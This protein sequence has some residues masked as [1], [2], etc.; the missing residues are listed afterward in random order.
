MTSTKMNENTRA[1]GPEEKVAPVHNMIERDFASELIEAPEN[2]VIKESY[3]VPRMGESYTSYTDSFMNLELLKRGEREVFK[4]QQSINGHLTEETYDLIRTD[5]LTPETLASTNPKWTKITAEPRYLFLKRRYYRDNNGLIHDHLR[6]D[7]I[8]CEPVYVFD[9]IMG[10]HLMNNHGFVKKIHHSLS[11]FY[12]NITR[13]LC[14]KALKFCS[15]CNPEQKIGKLEKFKHRNIYNELMPLERVHIEIFEPF[16]NEKIEKKYSHI[17]YCRDYHSRYIWMLPLKN[18]KFK[19]LVPTMASLFLSFIRQPIFIETASL[20]WQD[21]FD[22]CE[23]IAFEYDLQIG[24]GTSK[25]NTFHAAGIRQMK[26]KLEAHREECLLSWNLCLKYGSYDHNIRHNDRAGGV[27]GDLLSSQIQECSLKFKEKIIQ[28][29]EN[30]V[31]ESVLRVDNGLIF[32]E[33]DEPHDEPHDEPYDEFQFEGDQSI[34][35]EDMGAVMPPATEADAQDSMSLTEAYMTDGL[36]KP[37]VSKRLIDR[38][39]TSE[40]SGPLTS[41]YEETHDSII[42]KKH[43]TDDY[44]EMESNSSMKL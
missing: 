40:I 25:P 30:A 22:I 17:L 21:M 29:L 5:S 2:I 13:D 4:F 20:D 27:P 32:L 9:M 44:V 35:E 38:Q 3:I 41:Y 19:H 36:P 33:V 11:T 42:S 26:A 39:D 6:K 14:L 28:I 12:S 15:V 18:T 7:K 24:L 31:S 34:D 16:P 8:V 43:K 10:C 23:K 1:L 37:R